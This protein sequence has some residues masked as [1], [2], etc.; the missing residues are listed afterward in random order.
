[1]V[2]NL[3]VKS[4]EQLGS[5]RE[6]GVSVFVV[7]LSEK[8]TQVCAIEYCKTQIGKP[9]KKSGETMLIHPALRTHAFWNLGWCYKQNFVNS[10]QST[11]MPPYSYA[12]TRTQT[13]AQTSHTPIWSIHKL[14]SLRFCI[15]IGDTNADAF[16]PHILTTFLATSAPTNQELNAH[17]FS[18]RNSHPTYIFEK[19]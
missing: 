5:W 4:S 12:H 16:L 15:F 1:M 8:L 18:C 19:P 2:A 7:Q 10:I 13:H 11:T 14:R 9:K 6:T 3:I 17:F